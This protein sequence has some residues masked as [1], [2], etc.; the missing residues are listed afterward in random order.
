VKMIE[1]QTFDMERALYGSE[2]LFVKNCSFDGPADGESAFK[3][4][5]DIETEHCFFNLR[6]PFWHDDGITIRDSEMTELCRAALWY[7]DHIKIMNS[8]MHGIKALRE[9]SD[10]TIENSDII[11][12]EFGWSVRNIRMQHSTAQSEYFMMRSEELHFEDVQFMGKYSFQYI[13]NAVFENCVFDTKDAFWHSENVTVANSV[14]KGEYLAW[15][16]EGLTLVNCKIIGTQ[17]LCYC[18]NLKLVDCEMVDTDLAFEKS[19]VEA[20]VTTPIVSIKNP[21]SGQIQVP[22]VG[23]IIMDDEHARG[24]IITG[25]PDFC[26]TEKKCHC[27]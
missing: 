20:T 19:Q 9:C 25:R 1:N 21:L 2:G 27:A 13:R 3:E 15:Y 7:S 16:S 6:Y 8:K 11:S 12:P 26:N 14:V 24:E 10:V 5:R 17:P 23:E 18:K 22:E 4:G